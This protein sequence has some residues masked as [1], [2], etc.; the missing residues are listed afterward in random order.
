[1]R[2]DIGR[3]RFNRHSI[4]FYPGNAN[5]FSPIIFWRPSIHRT[6][7]VSAALPV[8]IRPNGPELGR[9]FDNIRVTDNAVDAVLLAGILCIRL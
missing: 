6:G 1:M 4:E 7:G 2:N 8:T 9:Q 5:R 3:N